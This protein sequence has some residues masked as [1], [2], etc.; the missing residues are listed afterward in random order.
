[1]SMRLQVLPYKFWMV[2]IVPNTAACTRNAFFGIQISILIS[3]F[4]IAWSKQCI[5][6]CS[7]LLQKTFATHVKVLVDQKLKNPGHG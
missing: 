5:C 2:C 3:F 4:D 1:M 6:N 7:Q